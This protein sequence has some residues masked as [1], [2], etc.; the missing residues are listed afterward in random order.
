MND[1]ER[2]VRNGLAV[3]SVADVGRVGVGANVW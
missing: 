3:S 1:D 2:G